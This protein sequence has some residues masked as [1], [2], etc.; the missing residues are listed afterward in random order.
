MVSKA[1]L[2]FEALASGSLG[3]LRLQ[4]ELLVLILT[5]GGFLFIMREAGVAFIFSIRC[6]QLP[7]GKPTSGLP[8]WTASYRTTVTCIQIFVAF[9]VCLFLYLYLL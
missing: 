4:A 2:V 6:S 3:F 1:P 5:S 7:C 8:T 9:V